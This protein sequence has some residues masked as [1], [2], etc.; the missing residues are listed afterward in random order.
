MAGMDDHIKQARGGPAFFSTVG[1][2]GIAV[3]LRIE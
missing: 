2:G 3:V 1:N